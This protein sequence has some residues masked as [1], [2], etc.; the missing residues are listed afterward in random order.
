M[1]TYLFLL[2]WLIVSSA[3][4]QNVNDPKIEFDK[5][6]RLLLLKINS[7][8]GI[9]HTG[10]GRTIA[11][12]KEYQEIKMRQ[13]IGKLSKRRANGQKKDLTQE[14]KSI[15]KRNIAMCKELIEIQIK[16]GVL[17]IKLLESYKKIAQENQFFDTA[18]KL[19]TKIAELKEIKQTSNPEDCDHSKEELK[20][21]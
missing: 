5:Q 18:E 17:E 15:E 13:K 3:Y 20:E 9:L 21:K 2:F 14:L 4:S 19:S 1:K 11:I 10:S 8:E 7:L 6:I 12:E 16:C